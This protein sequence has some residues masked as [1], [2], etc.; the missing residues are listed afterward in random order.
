MT[1]VK[2]KMYAVAL[3][4]LSFALTM[5]EKDATALILTSF[6]SIPMFFSKRDWIN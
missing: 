4:G 5:I 1:N 3:F 2:N 6:I